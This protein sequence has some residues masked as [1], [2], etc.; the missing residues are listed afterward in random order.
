M[1]RVAAARAAGNSAQA[2]LYERAA[3]QFQLAAGIAETE[4]QTGN[5]SGNSST[6]TGRADIVSVGKDL[7]QR[8]LRV[9]EH[10]SFGGVAPVHKG[11]GHY[12]GRAIDINAVAGRDVDNPRAAATLDNLKTELQ[13]KGMTVLWR[14]TGHYG[15]M[16][17][18]VPK[19]RA[20]AYGGVFSDAPAMVGN[21]M[22]EA[23]KIGMLN[24]Q[25]LIS[26]LGKTAAVEVPDITNPVTTEVETDLTPELLSMIEGKLAK[27][28]YALENNQDTHARI[29]KNSM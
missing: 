4:G 11:R 5:S 23:Q 16:H 6:S 27:V 28:L 13:G 7:Q 9:A 2:T 3:S 1:Q 20:A 26:K 17:A 12:E 25:S 14:T 8:G 24:P 19:A 18:E 15:H 29:L 10:P 22:A 21:G